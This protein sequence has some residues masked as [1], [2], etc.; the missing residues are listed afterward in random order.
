L[1]RHREDRWSDTTEM[2]DALTSLIVREGHRA[3]S[4]DIAAYLREVID[5]HN[6]ASTSSA[7]ARVSRPVKSVPPT[8]VVVLAMEASPPPRSLATP[9]VS[10]AAL[11]SDWSGVVSEAGGEIWE[12]GEGSMLVV[13]TVAQGFRETVT[14]A[15]RTSLALQKHSSM[16]GYRLSVGLAPGVAR[17][18]PESRRPPEAW[19]LAG[20]FYLARWMMNLSAHRG[21][22]LLTEVGARQVEGGTTLLGRIPIQG[23]KYINLYEVG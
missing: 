5:A 21:R 19:E 6:A 8:P 11:S 14:R 17:I 2:A 9:R 13:W 4:N 23:N 10:L 16:S 1:S 18:L 20:P 7:E 12:R 22:V 3:T 15:V